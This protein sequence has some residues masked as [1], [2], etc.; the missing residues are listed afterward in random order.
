M[1]KVQEKINQ[2]EQYAIDK[3]V[4][5]QKG[6][7]SANSISESEINS[8]RVKYARDSEWGEILAICRK[9]MYPE[10]FEKILNDLINLMIK[11]HDLV[12]KSA[13]ITFVQD[14]ILENRLEL[15]PPKSSK[16]IAQRLVDLYS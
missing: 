15:I 10:T 13:A 12:T 3:G 6:D 11:G 7:G 9:Q 14:A 4:Y 16:K 1:N 8:L 5:S 2:L